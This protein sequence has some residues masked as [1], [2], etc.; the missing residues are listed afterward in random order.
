[1]AF[2]LPSAHVGFKPICRAVIAGLQTPSPMIRRSRDA[3]VV[4]PASSPRRRPRQACAAS[5]FFPSRDSCVR[6]I[7]VIS[8]VSIDRIATIIA[9]T[10]SALAIGILAPGTGAMVANHFVGER[11]RSASARGH[12][13]MRRPGDRRDPSTR[14]TEPKW[15]RPPMLKRMLRRVA[16]SSFPARDRAMILLSVKAGLRACEIAG[17]DWSMV[18]DTQGRVSGT[19]HVRDV[20]AKK[21]GGRRIPIHPDLRRA[22]E[23]LA[24]TTEPFG[25]V[26]RSYHWVER[27]HHSVEQAGRKAIDIV[28]DRWASALFTLSAQRFV[29]A[30]GSEELRAVS[31]R[32][33]GVWRLPA[34]RCGRRARRRRRV[35]NDDAA[36][37][38][39]RVRS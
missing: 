19:I 11:A 33:K 18:L 21:R 6:W 23:R 29:C 39:L 25:P 28:A 31:R 38:R 36:A 16:H 27:V 10:R 26:I 17:L 4:R 34:S 2:A 24:G 22:L 15:S 32:R 5:I 3:F 7:A 13:G 1:M 37:L 35:G 14:Q 8:F 20:I 9:W 30:V 12:S